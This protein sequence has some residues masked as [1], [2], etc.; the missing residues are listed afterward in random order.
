MYRCINASSVT[1]GRVH[2]AWSS[3]AE[4]AHHFVLANPVNFLVLLLVALGLLL[5]SLSVVR[6]DR[7]LGLVLVDRRRGLVRA[8]SGSEALGSW[9]EVSWST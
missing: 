3:H 1:K 6:V 7:S 4:I 8:G 5:V 9:L 2:I